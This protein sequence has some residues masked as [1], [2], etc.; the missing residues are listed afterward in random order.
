[1]ILFRNFIGVLLIFFMFLGGLFEKPEINRDINLYNDYIGENAKEEYK[2]K[3]GMDEKIF[4]EKITDNMYVED[5]K[6]IYYNPWDAQYLSYLVVDYKKEDY[7]NEVD[8]L[9]EYNSTDY[10]GYYNV[11][12]FTKYEL[13][14]MY[15]NPY[16]GFVYAITDGKEKIIYV[17]LIFCNYFYDL[18]YEKYINTD[19]L[20]DGFDATIDNSY[21]KRMSEN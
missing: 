17:E 19:F 15:A 2:V 4:P 12:G 20:P 14:A 1:M 9:K 3:W 10:I 16:Y 5:Y 7:K 6:M 21:E 8:R 18:E 13:L 11:T